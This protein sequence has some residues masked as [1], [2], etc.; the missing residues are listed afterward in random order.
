MAQIPFRANT[1]TMTFPLLSELSGQSII[2]PQQDQTYVPGVSVPATAS[3][4]SSQVPADRGLPQIYYAHNVMPS[5]YGYQSIGYDLV[6]SGLNWG[7]V[8]PSTV[9]FTT[10][11]LIQGGQIIS[12]L[13]AA[14]GFKSYIS[15]PKTGTNS[16]FILD[17]VA[18]QWKLVNGAPAIAEDTEVTVATVNGVSYIFFSKLGAY[19]YDNNTNTLIAR[20]LD[21]LAVNTVLGIVSSNGYLFAYKADAVAWSSVVDVED[22]VPSDVSGAG[23]G[24]VQEARGTIVTCRTTSLGLILYTTGNAVSVIYSGNADFPW[25]FKHISSSGGISDSELV[26]EEQT[27]GFQQVYSTNGFQQIGH[28]GCKTVS[29]QMTDFIAGH[30][31]EDYDTVTN[32]FVSVEFDWI[33]RK[34]LAVI[35]D[36]YVVVS[37]GLYPDQDFTHAIVLDLTQNRMGKLKITHASCFELRSLNPETT[38]TPRGS[39]AFLQSNGDVE[40][41]NFNFNAT[42]PD[43]VLFMGKYQYVRQRGLEI[44]EVELENVKVGADFKIEA[45]PTLDG[46]NYQ[47]S[48]QGFLSESS[49]NYRKFLFSSMV[50]KNISLMFTGRFNIV[51]LVLWF[52]PHGRF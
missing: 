29:P 3:E 14:T 44:H 26:S 19:I 45:F 1:Q 12:D 25:N 40:S 38:E 28:T 37:Y 11:K 47:P 39:I 8:S 41:V 22:F 13:P 24:S 4:G 43:S 20:T 30:L 34:S 7:A 18:K 31:F 33:M 9:D 36:R 32:Q 52:S 23:G 50:G 42:A 27:G 48:V 5:T 15:V 46:K 6:Y 2:V 10:A 35:A 16:V 21:G 49:G 17:P 51:S